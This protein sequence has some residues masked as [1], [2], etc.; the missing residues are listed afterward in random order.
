MNIRAISLWLVTQFLFSS[1]FAQTEQARHADTLVLHA[2]A[3]PDIFVR[4]TE[5]KIKI[6]GVLDDEAWLDA[7]PYENYFFQH[8]P[9]D[10]APSTEKTRV[11]V[12]QDE[13]MIY[14]G[15]QCYD[16]EP[17]K[18]FASSMRRD[19]IYG[20]GDMIELL[21]DTFQDNRNSYA[22]NTNPL[23]GKG[24]AIVS[25]QG[26]HINK[27]WEA[28][29]YME[30][31]FNDEGWSA[32]YAIPFKSLKYQKGE[33]ID[34]NFNMSREIKH[35]KEETYLI[36]VPRDLGHRAKFRGENWARLRNIRPPQKGL[37]FEV[38]PYVLGGQ[39]QIYGEDAQTDNEFHHGIDFKYDFTTQLA[40]DLTYNT[41]FAQVEADQEIV[42]VT[43]FN[44]QRE[45]KRGFFLQNAGLFQFGPGSRTQRNFVLFDSR[46]IGIHDR[47]RIPLHGGGKLTGRSGK[48]SI[49]ALSMQSKETALE[50]GQVLGSTNY[51]VIRIKRD[52]SENSSIGMMALSQNTTSQQFSR[53]FGMDGIWN[54]NPSLKLDASL[55]KSFAP[56]ASS[57]SVAGDAGFVYLKN[58]LELS[59]RYTHIDSL[60]NPAMGFVRRPNIRNSDSEIELT[61]WINNA[62]LQNIA[63]ESGM[64]YIT[65]HQNVLQTRD[66]PVTASLT[67]K[68]GDSFNFGIVQSFEYVPE[69]SYIRDIKIET[70]EYNTLTQ[71]MSM[72]SFRGRPLNGSIEF[73]WGELFDGK[74]RTIQM[75]ATAKASNHL[76]I[77]LAYTYYDLNLVH[78]E[79]ESH[80]L[81]TRLTYSFTPDF[82]TKAY[83]QW[84]TADNRFSGNIIVDWAYRPRSHLYLVY[85]ENHDTQ[86]GLVA[87][88]IFMM[89]MTYLWQI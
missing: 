49:A 86:Q 8:E 87:D 81:G 61:K 62:Y 69:E 9:L 11:M 5:Q 67:L 53:A 43:R 72:R 32:E 78:G 20:R 2:P 68:T 1:A 70:G 56:D 79:L 58:W 36:P 80:I 77:D 30:G 42:N 38:Y 47:Q 74:H 39:T 16:S 14:F 65:D 40:L 51:S 13:K 59:S 41:D 60:F 54:V 33:V 3:K 46:S 85:N 75:E 23:G 24:D 52:V 18:I 25:E 31:A 37:N 22:F 44:I 48:Y 88:R 45:E 82:F 89:K 55:A 73:E 19:Q 57:S 64:T 12:L 27:Q 35:R 21:L 28:V 76:G 7:E 66:L 71:R 29:V 4:S 10:R 84:N 34:W 83:L 6:D 63:I 15:I 50:D 26:N 17:E